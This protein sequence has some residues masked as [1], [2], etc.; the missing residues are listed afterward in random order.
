MSDLVIRNQEFIQWARSY[1]GPKFHALLADPP[2]GLSFMGKKWDSPGSPAAYQAQAKQWGE[3]MLPVLY[4]GALVFMFGGTRTAHRL[5]CGMEDAGFEMFDTLMWIHSQGFPKGRGIG[6]LVAK[7]TGEKPIANSWQGHMTP[8]FKPAYEPILCFRAPRGETYAELAL[9]SGAGALNA[10]GGRIGDE[11]L[12]EATAGQSRIGTFLR[13]NMVTP[14]RKGRYP[15]NV[16]FDEESAKL[17]DAQSGVSKSRKDAGG[18]PKKDGGIYLH[19]MQSRNGNAHTDEGGA[20]RFFYVA[21]ASKKERN[22]GLA[23]MERRTTSDGRKKSIDNPFQRGKTLR[24]NDHPCVKPLALTRYV[25]T[26]LLPPESVVPRRLLV[27]FAGSGS[28]MI[29]ALQAGWNE[30]VG[31]EQDAHFCKIAAKAHR[32]SP[33]SPR[34]PDKKASGGS[35]KRTFDILV[36]RQEAAV[37]TVRSEILPGASLHNS[38]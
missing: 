33:R 10:D 23:G 22:A 13:N 15:A 6:G 1:S 7:R 21:K 32:I 36:P 24:H 5:T 16:L 37:G 28:E 26:L 18:Q 17:L 25:A 4:P 27:P 2:Y 31:I 11:E 9:T 3:A 19:G 8:A 20:S 34:N 38:D 35:D 30:V 14:A 29:G 12:P